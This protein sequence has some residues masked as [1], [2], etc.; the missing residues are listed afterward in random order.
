VPTSSPTVGPGPSVTPSAVNC[1]T[2]STRACPY[3][4]GRRLGPVWG[5]DL[6][7][8]GVARTLAALPKCPS[9]SFPKL[10]ASFEQGRPHPRTFQRLAIARTTP[11]SLIQI[12]TPDRP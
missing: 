8:R 11:R 3:R 10:S 5:C 9:S 12:T 1:S 4:P 6:G 2:R 7:S